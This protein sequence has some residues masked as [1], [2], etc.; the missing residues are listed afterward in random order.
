MADLDS[1]RLEWSDGRGGL[2]G[3]ISVFVTNREEEN[4]DIVARTQTCDCRWVIE[5]TYTVQGSQPRIL[6]V[7]APDGRPLHTSATA[8]AAVLNYSVK[9]CEESPLPGPT[10]CDDP[11]FDADAP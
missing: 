11:R 3:P 8:N 1:G 9:T 10:L 4:F 2:V 7:S 6:S 5:F